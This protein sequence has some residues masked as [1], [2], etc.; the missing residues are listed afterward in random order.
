MRNN[1]RRE[2]MALLS[3]SY[4]SL[5]VYHAAGSA[6]IGAFLSVGGE[7]LACAV[8]PLELR[9]LNMVGRSIL[10]KRPVRTAAGSNRSE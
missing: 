3:N 7:G 9:K 6:L 1:H 10:L 8:K 2:K 4:I 5:V